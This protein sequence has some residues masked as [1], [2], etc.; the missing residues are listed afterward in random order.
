MS[1]AAYCHAPNSCSNREYNTGRP[2]LSRIDSTFDPHHHPPQQS[3]HI[4]RYGMLF[5][6]PT[7]WDQHTLP[8]A[9]CSHRR[10]TSGTRIDIHSA[11]SGTISASRM[12]NALN[13]TQFATQPIPLQTHPSHFQRD[14]YT[15]LRY[16]RFPNL[17][18]VPVLPFPVPH[19][20]IRL[21]LPGPGGRSPP[22]VSDVWL[23]GR[24]GIPVRQ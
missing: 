16:I 3:I 11:Q 15:V 2:P 13:A 1:E 9:R 4:R 8:G 7:R 17:H 22:G 24:T 14:P 6:T 18:L 20:S 23:W 5:S 12:Q 19:Q 10:N 21:F